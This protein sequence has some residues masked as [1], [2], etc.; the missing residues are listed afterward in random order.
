MREVIRRIQIA[1]IQGLGEYLED[2]LQLKFKRVGAKLQDVF[3]DDA[4]AALSKRLTGVGD[5]GKQMSHAY[6]LTVNMHAI[7]A[8]NYAQEI[9]EAKVTAEVVEAI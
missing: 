6:P 3:T 8:I 9:G 7:R 4:I 1:R 2:Y 5:H